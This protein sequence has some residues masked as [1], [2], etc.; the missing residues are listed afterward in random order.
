[1]LLLLF[2][3]FLVFLQVSL[4]VSK[5]EHVRVAITPLHTPQGIRLEP[6]LC[7]SDTC[8]SQLFTSKGSQ[9]LPKTRPHRVTLTVLRAFCGGRTS[10]RAVP[11]HSNCLEILNLVR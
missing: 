6:S 5:F 7:L 1:M 10:L 3:M 8:L 11:G 9:L 4:G 2:L